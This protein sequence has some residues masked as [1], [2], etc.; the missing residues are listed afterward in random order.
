MK[1]ALPALAAVGAT[2]ALASTASAA[3]TTLTCPP[4]E[5]RFN[6]CTVQVPPTAVTG[7]ASSVTSTGA[8]V[9]GTVNP[10]GGATFFAFEFGTTTA[11]GQFAGAGTLP[12]PGDTTTHAVSANLTGLAPHT[13]YHYRLVALNAGGQST[14]PN[15]PTHPGPGGLDA[16]FTTAAL[17]TPPPAEAIFVLQVKPAIVKRNHRITI[18]YRLREAGKSTITIINSR[19]TTVK[20]LTRL[21]HAGK[22]SHPMTAPNKRGTYE[23][24]V[25]VTPTNG[26][27]SA[28]ASEPL[29][30]RR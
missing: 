15:V 22:V 18:S 8:T 10:N 30:V 19:G 27:A 23:V 25:T 5:T 6:Y 28:T 20:T 7:D 17:T 29:T 24:V 26:G 11:Y 4:G 3:T 12:L 13:T 14:D 2:L 16:T 1:K 21:D 9:A